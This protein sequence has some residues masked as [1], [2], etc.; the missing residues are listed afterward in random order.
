MPRIHYFGNDPRVLQ[1]YRWDR[2]LCGGVGLSDSPEP[3]ERLLS[4]SLHFHIKLLLGK[5]L[6]VVLSL[7]KAAELLFFFFFLVLERCCQVVDVR[8]LLAKKLLPGFAFL[9]FAWFPGRHPKC[10]PVPWS[11]EWYHL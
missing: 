5:A 11:Q 10:D 8:A 4:R 3:A 6:P 2:D 7:E 9:V 1:L